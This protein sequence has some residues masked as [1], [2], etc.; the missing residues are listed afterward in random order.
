MRFLG[1]DNWGIFQKIMSISIV[2]NMLMCI[3]AFFYLIPMIE[4][5]LMEEKR[6]ATKD[7]LDIAYTLIAAYDVKAKQ[8]EMTREQA[9]Q[10]A[11]SLIKQLR[12]RQNDYYWINDLEPKMLMH[13]IFSNLD[14]K[15]LSG[16]QDPTGK[17][18]FLEMVK[19][20]KERG[21]GFVEYMWPK[22]GTQ[23]P[24]SKLSYVKLFKPWGWVVGSGIY[25]DDVQTEITSMKWRIVIATLVCVF[26][27]LIFAYFIANR[28]AELWKWFS[29][30]PMST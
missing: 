2:F 11:L 27:V 28:I 1:F 26:I 24:V 30:K 7:V 13:P 22:P 6:N 4:D 14:G 21:E 23:D 29:Q 8:G 18:L 5:K 19:T 25:V 9:Q 16:D 3:G 15:N 17:F 12:Y 20:A 10:T